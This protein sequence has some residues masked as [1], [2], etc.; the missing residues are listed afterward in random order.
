MLSSPKKQKDG[1]YLLATTNTAVIAP[2]I[3]WAQ[4]TWQPTKEWIIWADAKRQEI[5]G[6][7]LNHPK[8][9]SR[10]PRRDTLEGLF[11]PWGGQRMSGD[12]FVQ[13]D[14]APPLPE[15][16]ES[17]TAVWSLQ[18][19]RMTSTSITPV[20]QIESSESD[21]ADEQISL[22]GDDGDGDGDTVE[23]TEPDTREIQLDDIAPAATQAEAPKTILRSREWEGRKFLAKERVRETRLKAQ[24][25]DRVARREE[26]RFYQQFGELDENESSFSEYDLSDVESDI[27]AAE[28]N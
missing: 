23:A 17:G 22:F 19:I 5:L 7:F 27:S 3:R 6:E 16:G 9:F 13:L 14:S 25:A 24:I 1:S 8:W 20:W 2:E 4:G 18:G 21:P 28:S 15:K 11:A 12:L 26:E 10:P